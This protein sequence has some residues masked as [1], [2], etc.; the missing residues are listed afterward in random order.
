[1]FQNVCLIF[2][3]PVMEINNS[4]D[5]KMLAF[6]PGHAHASKG[7]SQQHTM[8]LHVIVQRYCIITI[9][10]LFFLRQLY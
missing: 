4:T 10:F 5:V 2:F 8:S 9:D 3:C 7:K 6:D 1:M